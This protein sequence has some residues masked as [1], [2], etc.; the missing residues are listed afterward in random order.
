MK[1]K[2]NLF[3]NLG[4]DSN[5][6]TFS[7]FTEAMTGNFVSTNT[8]MYLSK[9]LC[10]NIPKLNPKIENN[11]I[12]IE[13]E[14]KRYEER[15]KFILDILCARYEN[16]LSFLRDSLIEEAK[17]QGQ[18]TY[19]IEARLASLAYLLKYI[20]EYD[21]EAEIVYVGEISEQDFNGTYTDSI[22]LV[23]TSKYKTVEN[24]P[25]EI[26]LEGDV[27][28]IDI[29]YKEVLGEGLCDKLYGWFRYSDFIENK[30][31][32]L[33]DENLPA[34]YDNIIPLFDDDEYNYQLSSPYDKLVLKDIGEPKNPAEDDI[35]SISFNVIIPLFD[36]IN[37]DYKSDGVVLKEL[38][39]INLNNNE[40]SDEDNIYNP[41][42]VSNVPYGIWFST[43]P[44]INLSRDAKKNYAPTWSLVIGSQFKPFPYMNQIPN[45]VDRDG[46]T[47][48]YMT[49]AEVLKNQ[50][51]LIDKIDKIMQSVN[52]LS[53][54][55]D[56]LEYQF[57][58][59][60][61]AQGSNENILLD[62]RDFV[63]EV[64]NKINNLESQ[65]NDN[66]LRWV[67]REI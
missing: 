29:N 17:K 65:I 3:Y 31:E 35:R 18:T 25:S 47:Q 13:D 5:F 53:Q 67:N 42:Y 64:E 23:D 21:E 14:Q 60:P 38:S 30:I 16:K 19:T 33:I 34:P 61:N 39:Y 1:R 58:A 11:G 55:I 62:Y 54:R 49:F 59:S 45:E 56:D 7:N 20:K 28:A 12:E 46:L 40:V 48:A 43:T 57:K 6:L 37:L 15:K 9:F 8:K 26:E 10:L 27:N 36:I 63:Q 32:C 41:P 44:M 52:K 2:T 66:N 4:D 24:Y 50:N 51:N 22:C